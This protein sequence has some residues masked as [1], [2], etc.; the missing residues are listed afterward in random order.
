MLLVRSRP[1]ASM[2]LQSWY[3]LEKDENG[4]AC[5]YAYMIYPDNVKIITTYL[6]DTE[7]GISTYSPNEHI[8]K[9]L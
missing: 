4:H 9:F 3:D 5:G 1:Y 7:H 2:Y 6:N 8:K